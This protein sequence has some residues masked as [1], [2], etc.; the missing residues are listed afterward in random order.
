MD[1]HEEAEK[2]PAMS[3]VTVLQKKKREEDYSHD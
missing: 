1:G 2:L 3:K